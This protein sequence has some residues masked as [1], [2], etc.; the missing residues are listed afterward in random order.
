MP[1][2]FNKCSILSFARTANPILFSYYFSISNSCSRV[3]HIKD[4]GII[5]D[6]KLTFF[7]H[8][9]DVISR[10]N[11]IWG[12]IVRNTK[13]FYNIEA[14]RT[15][16]VSMVKSIIMYDSPIWRPYKKGYF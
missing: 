14:I 11:R 10:C 6:Q 7:L 2:N 3:F 4:L 16:Y 15:L 12:F 9:D 5:F 1:P 8:I 13:N